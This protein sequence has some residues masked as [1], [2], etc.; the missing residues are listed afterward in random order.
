M[1]KYTG[2]HSEG[3]YAAGPS[4]IRSYVN[5]AERGSGLLEDGLGKSA[6]N[7]MC[8]ACVDINA[9]FWSL[10]SAIIAVYFD[11]ASETL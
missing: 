2:R 11:F 4:R 3:Y 8:D 6:A 9:A 7:V 5:W 10:M 1:N